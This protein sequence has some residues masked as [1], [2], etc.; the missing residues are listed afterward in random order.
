M[1]EGRG[2]R[3]ALDDSKADVQAALASIYEGFA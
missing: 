2:F 1:E 3:D